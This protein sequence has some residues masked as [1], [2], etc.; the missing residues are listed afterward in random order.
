MED[1]KPLTDAEHIELT[2]LLLAMR[3]P[4]FLKANYKN[5]RGETSERHIQPVRLWIGKTEWHPE[6]GLM[7]TANDLD[8]NESRDFRLADF[9][10]KS[11][12]RA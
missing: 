4:V 6:P 3:E 5:W 8:K 10:M 7:L 1:L 11:F 2:N 9:D 12:R